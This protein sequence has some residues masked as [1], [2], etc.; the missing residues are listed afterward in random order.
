[1]DRE[2]V[3]TRAARLLAAA[4]PW[5]KRM[6]LAGTAIYLIETSTENLL[7]AGMHNALHGAQIII[8]LVFT[9]EYVM[10]WVDD[11]QDHYGWHYPQSPM[12]L[13]DLIS[14]L[15]FWLGFFVPDTDLDLL[16][17]MRVFS[18]LKYFRYSRPLQL[19]ALG[20][21][22]AERAV[23]PL[24]FSMVIIVLFCSVAVF[25]AEHRYQ[26]DKFA[27]LFDAVYFTMVTVATVGYGDV[28]P[29]TSTGRLVVMFTFVTGLAVFAG[30]LGVVGASF[31]KV[32]EE[33]VDPNIDP[34]AEFRKERDLR[35]K[36]KHL[37]D[38]APA[39]LL[40]VLADTA[41]PVN[42]EPLLEYNTASTDNDTD[43]QNAIDAAGGQAG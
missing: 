11:A 9:I 26:P 12:G 20:F 43:R 14:I 40:G 13:V 4:D 8:M 15:P 41:I 18:L 23:R 35:R 16:R 27:T 38:S 32:L 37:A 5:L 19:T 10:R 21:Y 31:F 17:T 24:C 42:A 2:F 22:R 39:N 29:M 7:S 25:E 36:L 34:V 3:M 33:E 28:T 6:I 30:M 1:M